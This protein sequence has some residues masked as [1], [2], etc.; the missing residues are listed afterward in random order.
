M[1]IMRK[2]ASLLILVLSLSSCQMMSS[3]IHDD[4]LVAR[5]GDRK[6]Y[7][8]EVQQYIPGYVS[9][10]DSVNL[11]LQYINKWAT[12]LLYLDLAEIELSKDELDVTAELEDYRK[13]L[14]KYRYEQR[15]VNERLDTLVTED[16]LQDYYNENQSSFQLE[17]PVLRYRF[18]DIPRNFLDKDVLIKKVCSRDYDSQEG[19]DS[20]SLKSVLKFTDNTDRWTDIAVLAKDFG[21]DYRELLPKL[22]NSRI[23]IEDPDSGERKLAFVC[24]IQYTGTAPLECCESMIREI[25]LNV[26]KHELLLTLEQDLLKDALDHQK[27]V[28]Y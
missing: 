18:I 9:S 6:L 3:F 4:T 17:R 23:D 28:I 11:A 20:L 12:E 13:S 26:R 21:M 7:I 16:Q 22:S 10:E 27:F 5:V 8:S 24:E 19:I 1:Q 2:I 14:L 15:Y 25:L